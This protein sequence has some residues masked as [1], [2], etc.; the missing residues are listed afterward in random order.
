VRF[1][2]T[3]STNMKRVIGIPGDSVAF[4]GNRVIVNGEP[5]DEPYLAAGTLTVSPLTEPLNLGPDEYFV[6]GDNRSNSYDSRFLKEPLKRSSI[7]ATVV[8]PSTS[9]GLQPLPSP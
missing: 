9:S 1:S 7:V 4:A 2:P 6:M 5:L 8:G 3:E